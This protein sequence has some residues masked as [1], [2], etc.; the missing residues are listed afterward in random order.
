MYVDLLA[1]LVFPSIWIAGGQSYEMPMQYATLSRATAR[2]SSLHLS[3]S[4]S[5]SN[6]NPDLASTPVS[7][8]EE[9][10]RI[11]GSKV[12]KFVV[13]L[14]LIATHASFWKAFKSFW[15]ACKKFN[16]VTWL[17]FLV[18]LSLVRSNILVCI[19]CFICINI[20]FARCHLLFCVKFKMFYSYVM[21]SLLHKQET[22]AQMSDFIFFMVPLALYFKFLFIQYQFVMILLPSLVLPVFT[23]HSIMWGWLRALGHN[24]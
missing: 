16:T 22:A 6:S 23:A 5:I 24:I 15:R 13:F 18:V 3:R 12:W 4:K 11:I 8:D 2:P 21:S 9:V 7:P 1:S 20:K 10:Q 17:H 19:T 14:M